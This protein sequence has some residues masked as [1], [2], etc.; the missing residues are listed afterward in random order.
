MNYKEKCH[1]FID[2]VFELQDRWKSDCKT[3]N[4]V[5]IQSIPGEKDFYLKRTTSR[6]YICS[7]L[8]QFR[9]H[10]CKVKSVDSDIPLLLCDYLIDLSF[11]EKHGG[12][13]GIDKSNLGEE[14]K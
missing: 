10:Y 6:I 14:R 13:K 7:E 5:L 12:S 8:P 1:N 3:E 4:R 2:A 11:I 9:D